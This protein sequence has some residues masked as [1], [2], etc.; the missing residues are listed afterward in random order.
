MDWRRYVRDLLCLSDCSTLCSR[1]SHQQTV[2]FPMLQFWKTSE[3]TTV[4]KKKELFHKL[5]A[6][7]LA[8][9]LLSLS[10][11]QLRLE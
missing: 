4:L 11:L 1:G 3:H 2:F 5:S 9:D 6:V 10:V 7:C 8:T